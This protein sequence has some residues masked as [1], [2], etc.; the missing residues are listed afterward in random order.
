MLAHMNYD[1]IIIAID[2][3]PLAEKVALEGYQLANKLQA[4]IALISV[5]DT[6]LNFSEGSVTPAELAGLIKADFRKMHKFIIEQKFGDSRVR[7][8]VE[9]GVPYETII[10]IA[11]E[12]EADA[13]VIGTHG[14]TGLSHLI[15][16]SVAE[17]VIRHWTKPTFIIPS[18]K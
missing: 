10:R 5:A 17:K 13:I 9:E 4:D 1:K 7:S 2:D 14:R 6:T 18:A 12:W 8:F 15:M 11:K 16:G 3:G